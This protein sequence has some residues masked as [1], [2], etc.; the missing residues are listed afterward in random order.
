MNACREIRNRLNELLDAEETHLPDFV[1]DHL[2][3]CAGCRLWWKQTHR[4][5]RALHE[6]EGTL[7]P[8]APSSLYRRVR[9][10]LEEEPAPA[11][12]SVRPWLARWGWAAI[13]ASVVVVVGIC[14]VIAPR[15]APPD[16]AHPKTL[17]PNASSWSDLPQLSSFEALVSVPKPVVEVRQDFDWLTNAVVSNAQ[18]AA[19]AVA[20][21]Q[22]ETPNPPPTRTPKSAIES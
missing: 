1:T 21:P 10:A 18:S 2:S 14:T 3:E 12:S 6:T 9:S 5:E 8:S 22:G 16:S 19:R 4:V 20:S 17:K 7:T 11:P 13:A 15:S